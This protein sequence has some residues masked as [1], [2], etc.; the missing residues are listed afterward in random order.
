MLALGGKPRGGRPVACR[1]C[2]ALLPGGRRGRLLRRAAAPRCCAA[3]TRRAAAPRCCGALL[4]RADD[5]TRALGSRTPANVGCSVRRP[6]IWP[7]SL[8]APPKSPPNHQKQPRRT[9]NPRAAPRAA[10]RMHCT[11]YRATAAA[12]LLLLAL[13]SVIEMSTKC[14]SG[15][16]AQLPHICR[17]TQQSERD[18]HERKVR[19][20]DPHERN[21][22]EPPGF[23]TSPRITGHLGIRTLGLHG[24]W[25][26][27]ERTGAT[28]T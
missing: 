3:L 2:A 24:L 19:E 5:I 8:P 12:T 15:G 17:A 11:M 25:R 9:K 18:A 26:F 21:A 4:R 10:P 6:H 22:L 1:A 20:R 28:G 23:A 13:H 14:L 27:D 7:G 16:G